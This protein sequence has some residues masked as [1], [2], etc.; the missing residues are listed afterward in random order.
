MTVTGDCPAGV[1]CTHLT[2]NTGVTSASKINDEPN[3][4]NDCN[5][6]VRP[7]VLG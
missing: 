4:G 6:V 3:A 7:L 2:W 5:V 1:G